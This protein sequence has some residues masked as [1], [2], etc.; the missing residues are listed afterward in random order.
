M[1]S[2]KEFVNRDVAPHLR[3]LPKEDGVEVVISQ[4]DINVFD[5]DEI[6]LNDW[7]KFL[8]TREKAWQLLGPLNDLEAKGLVNKI[9]KG[10]LFVFGMYADL[11]NR[12]EGFK[13]VVDF[14]RSFSV[15]EKSVVSVVEGEPIPV[16]SVKSAVDTFLVGLK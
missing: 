14:V 12:Q 3:L 6:K 15:E 4:P 13:K 2:N 9:Q 1:S 7:F 10:R 8:S 5:L 16:E 11:K